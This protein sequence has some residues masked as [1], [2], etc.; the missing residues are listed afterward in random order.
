MTQKLFN[1]IDKVCE[2]YN[3]EDKKLFSVT[4]GDVTLNRIGDKISTECGR[5]AKE[6]LSDK[7]KFILVNDFVLLS[8]GKICQT[9]FVDKHFFIYDK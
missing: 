2:L 5:Y 1:I 7:R 3:I 9:Y 8:E 4:C 6:S